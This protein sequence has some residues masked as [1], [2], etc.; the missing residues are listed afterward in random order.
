MQKE[1]RKFQLRWLKEK[2]KSLL[3]LK[4]K[5]NDFTLEDW[6]RIELKRK[7]QEMKT[8]HLHLRM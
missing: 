6:E 7:V 3:I 5:M 4:P 8:H 1:K 2:C